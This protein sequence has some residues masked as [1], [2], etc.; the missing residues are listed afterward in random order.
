MKFLKRLLS[1]LVR[2]T[3]SARTVQILR[4]RVWYVSSYLPRLLA[5]RLAT[6]RPQ[7]RGFSGAGGTSVLVEKLQ[8]IN[9]LTPTEMCR[10]MAKYGSDKALH[11]Y[12]QLYSA[13]FRDRSN[14]PLRVLE[15]GLGSNN[16]AILSNMGVFGAPGASLRGWRDLFPL[17]SVYGADID[18]GILFE[19]DRITTFYCDQLDKSSIRAVWSQPALR[20]G[21]DIII[22]DGLHTF[23]AN[24]SFLEESLD[25]L[26]PG[27][28]YVV[29]DIGWEDIERW[30][31]CLD[32]VYS[33]QYP[34]HEFAF[35]VL[36]KREYN[37][38]LVIRRPEGEAV[39]ARPAV[40]GAFREAE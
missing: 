21:A 4:F 11:G 34:M 16:P 1:P 40:A 24:I 9:M 30:Y 13:A 8:A 32:K 28:I 39:L 27:G 2:R 6:R 37:N 35:V 7:V 3:L 10:V 15:L 18:R 38:M 22:E 20:G 14:R 12:T 29:E 31:E 19:E 26:R 25:H 36:A 23:E 17:A 33:K 5:C